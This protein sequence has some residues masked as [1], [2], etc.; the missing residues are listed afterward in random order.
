VDGGKPRFGFRMPR[1]IRTSRPRA[2]TWLLVTDCGLCGN[3]EIR[4]KGDIEKRTGVLRVYISR[5]EN[6]HTIPALETLEKFAR[7][8]GVPTYQLFYDG[9]NPPV[10]IIPVPQTDKGW[11]SSGRDARIL[12]R[13]RSL[14]SRMDPGNVK[15]LLFMAQKMSRKKNTIP[16][17]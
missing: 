13:F 15:L 14:M 10:P 2:H 5:V 17:S 6:R 1:S 12:H 7:A 11:G 4:P 9:E 16:G 8:L 3:R